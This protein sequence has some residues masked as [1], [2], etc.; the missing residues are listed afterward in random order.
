MR[1]L[2]FDDRQYQL[3]RLII[4]ALVLGWEKSEPVKIYDAQSIPD[5]ALHDACVA[6]AFPD[7]IKEQARL[8]DPETLGAYSIAWQKTTYD[9]MLLMP[10]RISTNASSTLVI[11][12]PVVWAIEVT[13]ELGLTV[14]EVTSWG[15]QFFN[16]YQQRLEATKAPA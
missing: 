11:Y 15:K 7:W 4:A 6:G 9:A 12:V 5:R 10:G 13:T 3:S 14:E 2:S 16:S 8:Y 1:E